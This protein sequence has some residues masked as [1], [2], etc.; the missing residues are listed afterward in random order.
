MKLRLLKFLLALGAVAAIWLIALP[1]VGRS[2]I[3]AARID[4]LDKK[5]VDP[6]AMYYT[7]LE[8][9]G[10]ILERLAREQR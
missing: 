6:S 1:M 2:S 5:K 3:V 8:A 10:P 7:E 4:W 9:M